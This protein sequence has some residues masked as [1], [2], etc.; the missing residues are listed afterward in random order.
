MAI[1]FSATISFT[2]YAYCLL[3][4]TGLRGGSGVRPARLERDGATF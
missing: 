2:A 4:N 1:E 3:L